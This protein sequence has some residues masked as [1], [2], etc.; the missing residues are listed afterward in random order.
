MACSAASLTESHS[1][2]FSARSVSA[3]TSSDSTSTADELSSPV[4]LSIAESSLSGVGERKCSLESSRSPS[5]LGL[6]GEL[7][8]NASSAVLFSVASDDEA[9]ID[10]VVVVSVL[11]LVVVEV[12]V[13]LLLL[14][15]LVVVVVVVVFPLLSLVLVFMARCFLRYLARRFLNQT[16]N[17]VQVTVKQ[18]S[19]FRL[20]HLFFSSLLFFFFLSFSLSFFFFFFLSFFLSFFSFFSSSFFYLVLN[21]S[22]FL[23][24]LLFIY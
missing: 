21:F 9:E 12:D 18:S 10:L 22:F 11:D 3:P 14:L 16:C 7:P 8:L 24:L 23:F 4:S 17:S 6:E 1:T 2:L 15:L 19:F 5:A 13:V 20:L